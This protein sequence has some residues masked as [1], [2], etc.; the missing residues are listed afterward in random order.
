MPE[1]IMRIRERIEE[2]ME[3]HGVPHKE[4]ES[5]SYGAI[6]KKYGWHKERR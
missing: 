4:A 3:A 6:T 1:K 2:S 5:R